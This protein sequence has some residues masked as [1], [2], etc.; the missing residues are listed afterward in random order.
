MNFL[1]SISLPFGLEPSNPAIET[2]FF[3]ITTDRYVTLHTE[4]HQSKQWDHFSHFIDIVK[5]YLE[6]EKIKIV[7]LGWNEVPITNVDFSFKNN[8]P[9]HAAYILQ[10]SLGHI[11]PENFLTQLCGFYNVPCTTLYSNTSLSFAPPFWNDSHKD[12]VIES[13][14]KNLKPSYA[15]EEHPKTINLISP[16]KAASTFLGS[17]S[18]ENDLEEQIP[19]YMGDLSH[20]TCLEVIPDFVP[21]ESFFPRSL[22]NVRLDYHF[23]ISKILPLASNR[24]VSLI[25]DQPIDINL[26]RQIRPA[27]EALCFKIDENFDLAYL[28]QVKK[29]AVPISIF[30][31]PTANLSQTRLKFFD[32][33]VEEEIIKT[34]KDLD[35]DQELCNNGFFKSSKMLFSKN[36]QYSTKASWE[37]NIPTREREK[38]IDSDSF[39]GEL[40]HLKLYNVND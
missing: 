39:W 33:V 13:C 31:T 27:T 22:V 23:D 1:Q 2:A 8:D 5:P 18:I 14:R 38:I 35:K 36:V 15:G 12:L 30:A 20:S 3:P 17:L 9:K 4:N 7:E 34:K 32:F 19:F 26:L 10:K 29:L 6:K 11:G 40:S 25:S 28:M 24:K 21:D 16:E 37:E